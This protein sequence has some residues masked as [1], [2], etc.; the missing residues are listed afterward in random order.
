MKFFQPSKRFMNWLAAYAGDRMTFDVGCGDG[1]ILRSLHRRKVKAIGIEMNVDWYPSYRT[2]RMFTCVIPMA[3]EECSLL[4]NT[5]NALVLFCRPSHN[6]FVHR[7]ISLLHPTTEVLYISN[8]QNLGIDLDLD[9]VEV[10]P[11]KSPKCREEV[12]YRVIRR[13]EESHGQAK[14]SAVLSYLSEC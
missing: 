2:R 9:H 3:A 6:E 14:Q 7:T 10:A 13:K 12:V 8:P 5:E 4:K 1:H 11:V